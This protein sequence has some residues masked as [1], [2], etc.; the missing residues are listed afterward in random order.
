MKNLEAALKAVQTSVDEEQS[1]PNNNGDIQRVG[2]VLD[3]MV[4]D[5]QHTASNLDMILRKLDK[6]GLR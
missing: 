2:A 6:R 4:S 1:M 3:Y 5:C